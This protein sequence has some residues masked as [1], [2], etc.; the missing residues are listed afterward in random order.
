[1][2]PSFD[3]GRFFRAAWAQAMVDVHSVGGATRSHCQGQH[4]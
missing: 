2:G 3:E 1:M 4:R